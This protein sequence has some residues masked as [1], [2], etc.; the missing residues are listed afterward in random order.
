MIKKKHIKIRENFK[1]EKSK[2]LE[3]LAS[4]QLKYDEFNQ[5]LKNKPIK[6]EFLNS[7]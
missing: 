4:K 2:H 5:S 7:F 6:G 3:R 1:K